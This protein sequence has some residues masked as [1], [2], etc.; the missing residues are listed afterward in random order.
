MYALLAVGLVSILGSFWTVASSGSSADAYAELSSTIT[1]IILINLLV[2]VLL[3]AGII[4]YQARTGN[5]Q[6]VQLVLSGATIFL[7]ITAVSL[8]VLQK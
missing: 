1:S 8:A 6:I 5:T 2:T 3:T 4:L 7:S